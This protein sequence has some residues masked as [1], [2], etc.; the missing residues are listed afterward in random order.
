MPLSNFKTFQVYSSLG[1]ELGKNQYVLYFKTFQ[2]YSSSL[3]L[4][5]ISQVVDFK[6][7]QVY[8]SFFFKLFDILYIVISKLFKF[9]VHSY[10]FKL[11]GFIIP[12]FSQYYK[13]FLCIFPKQFYFLFNFSKTFIFWKV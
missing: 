3:T 10:F 11:Y 9:I 12:Y 7:F 13:Y 8:S 5:E 6:T 2:V 4:M 1:E